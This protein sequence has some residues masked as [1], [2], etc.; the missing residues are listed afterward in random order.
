MCAVSDFSKASNLPPSASEDEALRELARSQAAKIERLEQMLDSPP[1]GGKMPSQE[2]AAIIE[3]LSRLDDRIKELEAGPTNSR[4]AKLEMIVNA[5]D[6]AFPVD[7]LALVRDQLV[8]LQKDVNAAWDRFSEDISQDRKR[9]TALELPDR[10]QPLMKDR[11]E[12]LQLLIV[13]NQGKMLARD[14]RHLLG[15]SAAQFS[16]LLATMKDRIESRPYHS[17]RR[18]HVILLKSKD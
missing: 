10:T 6:K 15:I 5:L 12:A 1:Q 17:D 14:A 2:K 11:S 4:L 9:I 13:A 18:Q 16:Q 8:T 7:E 3:A